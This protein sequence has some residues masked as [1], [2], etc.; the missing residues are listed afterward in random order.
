MKKYFLYLIIYSIGGFM[1]EIIIN[2][3]AYKEY[4]DN[5]LLIGPYQPLYGSGV[6]LAIIIY[7]FFISK[8]IK[9]KVA[10]NVLLV[11]T[12]ITTTAIAEIVTGYGYDYFYGGILWDYGEFLPCNFYYVCWLPTSLFGILSYFV[13]KYL[14]PMIESYIKV[15]PKYL[16]Y[17]IIVIF[18]VDIIVSLFFIL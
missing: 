9:N 14:H 10:V 13:I 11:I 18:G 16:V 4:V 1:L 6:V 15:L 2:I 17:A 12:A 3:I 8:K 5:S 7:D